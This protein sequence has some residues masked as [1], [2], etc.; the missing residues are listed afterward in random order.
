[1]CYSINNVLYCRC[2]INNEE[3]INYEKE[4]NHEGSDIDCYNT[5]VVRDRKT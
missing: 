2:Y 5:C 1:M 4:N 3:E